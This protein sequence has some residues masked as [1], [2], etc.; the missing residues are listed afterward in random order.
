VTVTETDKPP[1]WM[2]TLGEENW[3]DPVMD[4][5]EMVTRRQDAPTTYVPNGAVYA[6]GTA[7][8]RER[9]TFYTDATIGHP[10]PLE[11]SADVDTPLDLAWCEMLMEAGPIAADRNHS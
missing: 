3:L 8:L 1:Q 11:R 9:E 7:W 10:M 6:A 4:W 5:D 2:Y